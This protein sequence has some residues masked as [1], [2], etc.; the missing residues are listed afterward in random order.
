[1]AE[2]HLSLL[3]D[4]LP[5]LPLRGSVL[6]PLVSTPLQAVQQRSTHLIEDVFRGDGLVAVVAQRR[7]DDE[8][9]GPPEARQEAER[10]LER[11]GLV[12]P[13]SPEY[14]VI[15]TYLDWPASLP[16]AA[17]SGARIDVHHAHEVLDQDH[18]NLERVKDRVLEYLAVRK[19]KEERTGEE[20]GEQ[21]VEVGPRA[22]A[23]RE[24]IL[25]FFGPPGVGKTSLGQSIA[26]AMGPEFV[27]VSPGGIRDEA[28][29]RGHPAHTSGPCPAASSR[30]FAAPPSTILSSCWMKWTS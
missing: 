2:N 6:Y 30:A 5:V 17:S 14:G 25:C 24:P 4:T 7:L 19:L 21:A 27:R 20:P 10:E 18:Y 1:M 3:P 29:I 12:P 23:L 28:E 8:V 16:W 22:E 15:R 9:P 11:L 13:V 26:R